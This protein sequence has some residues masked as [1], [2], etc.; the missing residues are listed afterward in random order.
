[1]HHNHT[2]NI[3]TTNNNHNNHHDL[4]MTRPSGPPEEVPDTTGEGAAGTG[5][6][7]VREATGDEGCSPSQVDGCEFSELFRKKKLLEISSLGF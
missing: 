1:M 2:K 7:T 3:T 6:D 5:T 4:S